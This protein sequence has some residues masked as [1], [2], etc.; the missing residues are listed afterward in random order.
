M[1]SGFKAKRTQGVF[2][3]VSIA[4]LQGTQTLSVGTCDAVTATGRSE[5]DSHLRC[6]QVDSN[7]REL[8]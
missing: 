1:N 8:F 7:E 3:K 5:T 2:D 4:L 6:S